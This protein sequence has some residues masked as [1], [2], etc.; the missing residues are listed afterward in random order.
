MAINAYMHAHVSQIIQTTPMMTDALYSLNK[1]DRLA[2]RQGDRYITE[3]KRNFWL[4]LKN[5]VDCIQIPIPLFR[6]YQNSPVCGN[7]KKNSPTLFWI[8][9]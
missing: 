7:R 1:D 8:W 9:V 2:Q 6:Y 3:A 4:L 5:F